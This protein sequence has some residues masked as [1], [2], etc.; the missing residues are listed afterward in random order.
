VLEAELVDNGSHFLT[1]D[2]VVIIDDI[3][4]FIGHG[5]FPEYRMNKG[6]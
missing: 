3:E 4:Q 5:G 1:R 6:P 2:P